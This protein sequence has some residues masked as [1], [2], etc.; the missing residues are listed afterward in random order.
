MFKDFQEIPLYSSS[1]QTCENPIIQAYITLNRQ[2]LKK[3]EKTCGVHFKT[4]ASMTLVKSALT[5][6]II[7]LFLNQNI[8]C[9]YSK[10]P[11]R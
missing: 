1:L 11:S 9:G 6:K 7:F 4:C 8:C 5:E 3:V 10:E 2:E